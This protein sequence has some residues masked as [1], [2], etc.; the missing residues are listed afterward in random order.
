MN[1]ILTGIV[2][3]ILFSNIFSNFTLAQPCSPA[4]IFSASN[5]SAT[6][7]HNQAITFNN[8]NALPGQYRFRFY[9]S[10]NVLLSGP[11]A[12]PANGSITAPFPSGSGYK[13]VLIRQDVTCK[14]SIT[15][16]F[17]VDALPAA[18]AFT[19]NGPKCANTATAFTVT[20]PLAGHTYSWNFGD[21]ASG[22]ANTASGTTANHAFSVSSNG[23][24]ANYN[25]L[26][27]V[28]SPLGC[29][30][31]AGTVSVPV[32][33]TPKINLSDP[34]FETELLW[35]RCQTD[36]N[37]VDSNY[38]FRFDNHSLGSAGTNYTFNWGD[39]TP[40]TIV[41]Q[42]SLPDTINHLYAS[43]GVKNGTLLAT[44]PNGCSSTF[45]F[46]VV[47]EKFPSASLSI[48]PAQVSICDGTTV[49]ISNNSLNATSYTWLW[50]DGDSLNT[51][52]KS[53]QTHLYK[54]SDSVACKITVATGL[55]LNMKLKAFNTCW[56]HDNT[57]PIFV[58]PL[59]RINLEFDTLICVDSATNLVTVPFD[60]FVCPNRMMASNF[61]FTTI[62]FNDPFST[63]SNPDSIVFNP[64]IPLTN[65]SHKFRPGVYNIV[66]K[67][68]NSCGTTKVQKRLVIR[69][70]PKARFQRNYLPASEP[71][72]TPQN[73]STPSDFT[74]ANNCVPFTFDLKNLS[75][76]TGN[77]YTWT[78]TPAGGA[79]FA[80]SGNTSSKIDTTLRFTSPGTY[81]I[82]LKATNI[83]GTSL[84]C[85]TVTAIGPPV[86]VP[87]DIKGLD[88]ADGYS[89]SGDTSIACEPKLV[90][91]FTN[92]MDFPTYL[93]NLTGPSGPIAITG[94]T[95]ADPGPVILNAGIY[96]MQL[97]GSNACGPGTTRRF[98]K[99]LSLPVA[100]A[101][102]DK[103]ACIGNSV[104]GIGAAAQP[105]TLYQWNNLDG[106]PGVSAPNQSS[107]SIISNQAGIFRYEL[108]ATKGPCTKKDTVVVLINSLPVVSASNPAVCRKLPL[109]LTGNPAGG[110]W[111]WIGPGPNIMNLI[112]GVVNTFSAAGTYQVRYIYQDPSTQC[113]DSVNTSFTLFQLP[114]VK[115]RDTTV[116]NNSVLPVQL[117][118]FSPVGGGTGVWTNLSGPPVS[119]GGQFTPS[120]SGLFT[121]VYTFT[122]G[123]GCVEDDSINVSITSP[124]P[125]EAGPNR[126][127]CIDSIGFKFSGFSPKGGIW[128]GQGASGGIDSTFNP[129]IAGLGNRKII[130]SVGSGLCLRND[131]L[132]VNVLP[133]PDVGAG[134]D[135]D[136]VCINDPAFSLAAQPGVNPPAGGVWTGPGVAGNLFNPAAAGTGTHLITYRFRAA[137]GCDS[138]DTKSIVVN[139]LPAVFAR[140]TSVCRSTS[141]QSVQMLNAG[142]TLP[143]SGRWDNNGS[144]LGINP[145]G[146][147]IPSVAGTFTVKFIWKSSK[148]CE[149]V[150]IVNINVTEPTVVE[151]GINRSLCIDST[152]FKLSGFSPK[153]GIWSGPGLNNST[154]SSFNPR[155]A[156]IG[157]HIL[158][159]SLGSGLCLRN[160]SLVVNVLPLPD[161]GA[162]PDQDTV[163]I[164]DSPFSLASQAGVN[165]P[166]GGVWTGPGVA[167]NLFN[168]AAA[169]TG[170]HL[171]TYRFRAANGCD[172]SDT[173][174]IVVNPLPAVFARDTSFCR[175]T[176]G[177]IVQMANAGGD[178]PG[179][180]RWDDNGS[181]LGINPNG[182]FIPA[183]VGSFTVKFI[184]KNNKTCESEKLVTINVTEP[185]VVEAGPSFPTC[186]DS[187]N[188]IFTNFSPKGGIWSGSGS[189]MS[190]DSVFRPRIAGTGSHKIIYS[191]GSGLCLRKDSLI[192]TVNPLPNV[193]AGPDQDT[194]CINDL[195][196]SLQIQPGVNPPAG[197]TWVGQGVN[198]FMFNPTVAGTGTHTIT[199]HFRNANGCDSSDTK[200]ILVNPLPAVFARDTSFCRATGGT[201]VQMANAGG[202]LPGFGRWDDNGSG[203]GIDPNGTF[204][205]ATVGSFTVKFIW[206]NN[207][208]CE[209]EKIVTIHV[210]EPETVLAGP[211]RSTCLDSLGY[212]IGG[213]FPKGGIWTGSGM[214]GN[215]DSTF[216]PRLAGLGF[217]NLVYTVGEGLCLRQD[218]M[219]ILVNPLPSID[220]GGNQDTICIN[221]APFD[222][223]LISGVTSAF[224]IRWSIISSSPAG[225]TATLSEDGMFNP[226]PTGFSNIPLS[227]TYQ[228][229][230]RT[231][232]PI[233]GCDSTDTKQIIVNPRPEAEIKG[234]GPAI[235]CINEPIRLVSLSKSS[236]PGLNLI[237]N[238]SLGNGT[239]ISQWPNLDSLLISFQDTGIKVVRLSVRN[240]RTC[241]DIDSILIHI[242]DRGIPKYEK[243]YNPTSQ[244]G[245]LTVTFSDLSTGFR[246][247]TAWDLGDGNFVQ[248]PKIF[249]RFF[250]MS[251]WQD[252]LYPIRFRIIN[253]C[254]TTILH[255]T[256]LVKTLP[257]ANISANGL[258]HCPE[259]NL[260]TFTSSIIGA[261]TTLLFDFGDGTI[262]NVAVNPN[263]FQEVIQH[264]YVNNTM[265]DLFFTVK[266]TAINSCPSS[267]DSITIRIKGRNFNYE[268][269]ID[270]TVHC[271]RG[272]SNFTTNP[273]VPGVSVRWDLGDGTVI[274]NQTNF[275]HTYLVPGL[276]KVKLVS[277]NECHRMTDSAWVRVYPNPV[278]SIIAEGDTNICLNDAITFSN[279][280]DSGLSYEWFRDNEPTPWSFAY[281]PPPLLFPTSGTTQIRLLVTNPV[282]LC[283]ASD[284]VKITVH[285]SPRTIAGIDVVPTI[286]CPGD[287]FKV[288]DLSS[289]QSSTKIFTGDSFFYPLAIGQTEFSYSYTIPG[290][291][292][293]SL[294][295]I[296]NC[297]S[298]TSETVMVQVKPVPRVGFITS[299][300]TNF[301]WT[302][303]VYICVGDTVRYT[304][305]FPNQ[306]GVIY[307]WNFGDN[308]GSVQISPEP[309]VYNQPGLFKTSLQAIS[310]SP[311]NCDSTRYIWVKVKGLPVA[312]IGPSAASICQFG[313][314]SFQNS[315]IDYI[316]HRWKV[317]NPEGADVTPVNQVF[318]QTIQPTFSLSG[319]YTIRLIVS[320][321]FGDEG[322]RDSVDRLI[323]VNPAPIAEIEPDTSFICL[324]EFVQFSNNSTPGMA[325]LWRSFGVP[326]VIWNNNINQFTPGPTPN[327]NVG[328]LYKFELRVTDPVSGCRSYD[329]AYVNVNNIP[330]A[331]ASWT[332]SPVEACDSIR[333]TIR[334]LS[335][336][337]DSSR[338]WFNNGTVVSIP[339][340]A[341][342][343]SVR[344]LQP[345]TLQA[346]L[347]AYGKCT[348]DTTE[349]QTI[350]IRRSPKA[351]FSASVPGIP[352][353]PTDTVIICA[354]EIVQF[355]NLHPSV[356]NI[357]HEWNFGD[358]TPPSILVSP[359]HTYLQTG[360]FPVSL[361]ETYSSS[362]FCQAIA[363]KWVLV[364]PAAVP[365]FLGPAAVCEGSP[366]SFQ[367]NSQNTSYFMWYLLQGNNILDS[368]ENL[369]PWTFSA[370]AAGN[371]SVRI[372]V[373]GTISTNSCTGSLEK[374]LSIQSRP[375]ASFSI[376]NP[377][378]CLND[379]LRI[380]NS[381][382]TGMNYSW[383]LG[384]NNTPFSTLY[385]PQP[386]MVGPSGQIPVRLKVT[387]PQTGCYSWDTGFV[388][389]SNVRKTKA[390]LLV[391]PPHQGCDTLRVL[392]KNQSIDADSAWVLLGY[393]NLQLPFSGQNPNVSFTYPDTGRFVT[394][395]VAEGLCNKDTIN[396]PLIRVWP[397]PKADFTASTLLQSN[398]I[399]DT[400][401]ICV[402]DTV[403]FLNSF[404]LQQGVR[405]RWKFSESG[406]VFEG[407]NP[408]RRIYLNA[409]LYAVRLQAISD[410]GLCL[411]ER[412][413]FVRVK[414]LPI[415]S[416]NVVP[417]SICAGSEVLLDAGNTQNAVFYRW[418]IT[419]GDLLTTIDTAAPFIH[420]TFQQPG[421]GN[422]SIRL[423]AF[424]SSSLSSCSNELTRSI[425]VRPKP[426]PK[427]SLND[428]LGCTPLTIS[429]SR[430]PEGFGGQESVF[431]SFGDNRTSTSRNLNLTPVTYINPDTLEMVRQVKLKVSFQGCSDS[432][433][434]SIRV[435]PVPVAGLLFPEGTNLTQV[436][437]LLRLKEDIKP[438]CSQWVRY[439]SFGDGRDTTIYGGPNTE[440][441][442]RYD[443]TG[444]YYLVQKVMD[445]RYPDTCSAT[446]EGKIVRVFQS[447]PVAV[448]NVNGQDSC[449]ICEDDTVSFINKSRFV[450]L[451]SFWNF[452]NGRTIQLLGEDRYQIQKVVYPEPGLYQ[453]SL[454]VKN[455]KGIDTLVKKATVRVNPKPNTSFVL[456]PNIFEFP[457]FD[458][459][460]P[461]RT[462]NL[463]TGGARFL[464]N[465]GEFLSDTIEAFDTSYYY[466]TPG[467]YSISLVSISALGCPDT[468][469][470]KPNIKAFLAGLWVPD[471]FSPN[472]DGLN[473]DW[474]IFH[475]NVSS[476]NLFVYNQWGE[477]IFYSKNPENRW[478]GTFEGK[479]CPNGS[480]LFHITYTLKGING[481]ESAPRT[482]NKVVTIKR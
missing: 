248:K 136:T 446:L 370:P 250:P 306:A 217:H 158:R 346:W 14:D 380:T 284:T 383:F 258:T 297:V 406:A 432:S 464:W 173:K 54:L 79:N 404:P 378:I 64:N 308:S 99:I 224:G 201:V 271:N 85:A 243:S 68:K 58:K 329:T 46:K 203:L 337:R 354:G 151:A 23:L 57:S 436:N 235:F 419:E 252:T 146:S 127:I 301:N 43:F 35:K 255:D 162:G 412:L 49:T 263:N 4:A 293:V 36:G 376:L 281:S 187:L 32:K 194:V 195:P 198:G 207:K 52:S 152:G 148:T 448:F 344:F 441:Y 295:A 453:V 27:S 246:I 454:T 111:K 100:N 197:G 381:S 289:N 474:Q 110:V 16:A 372:K 430:N 270:D 165:P 130:Y 155:T 233:T 142:G 328:G 466:S 191:V 154:D 455:E 463:T 157:S 482:I 242:I 25:V 266:V 147:F 274:L 268:M 327:F 420:Y 279:L 204:I 133:L 310:I 44:D 163:C 234:L 414:P 186:I 94:A 389:V 449:T 2:I 205:P 445:W 12:V 335:Q 276:Y 429:F 451:S 101:G 96:T 408:A 416:I 264:G 278:A 257:V 410:S 18:P 304:N 175:A 422:T 45:P 180:G 103:T 214:A 273:L 339:R 277:F 423:I 457:I 177:T 209:S 447:P 11:T 132:V 239:I 298:D 336:F 88:V 440:I 189:S 353:W 269:T 316:Q 394:K 287:T 267:T 170:T 227:Y 366:V 229:L 169:G 124:N 143:G 72:T 415:I 51:T 357:Q 319:Q 452:G 3:L 181:G 211:D 384:N 39:G 50:G 63:P 431:W 428:S 178:L 347:V 434:R 76:G 443:T 437:P 13:A 145:N 114:V 113:K 439:Y 223:N 80:G 388:S 462:R 131:S 348:I 320:N 377:S 405:Y 53:P 193:N 313:I 361:R 390:R 338:V 413:R 123:N 42:S 135:Q 286:L 349:I 398:W 78:V 355:N 343:V 244:C 118:N 367:N 245:P 174:S 179:F 199:Y 241:E 55:Q 24:S 183:T 150:K 69:D 391:N 300:K 240:L 323:T 396:G 283:T 213:F 356:P 318:N 75:T 280:S 236:I 83:C 66:A 17:N 59:P 417:N 303:T 477:Q 67:A 230:A 397:S 139:P 311:G 253:Q 9:S 387:I 399:T 210:T 324:G 421:Q 261:P 332:V 444:T 247:E 256:I 260:V 418:E 128:I 168:P 472:N 1:K 26:L 92:R 121:Y 433:I 22:T 333:I 450:T 215:T 156:G 288:K 282:S 291:Y 182:T 321:T 160:D 385:N 81:I 105:N 330:P 468:F 188:V 202:D 331:Q 109:T 350:R 164:N 369:S 424:N 19:H 365:N 82:T 47:N 200:S 315:S 275:N 60:L 400:I 117:Q 33:A 176:G 171:I 21:P 442:H 184:W 102:P 62:I 149:S 249:T 185:T 285:P 427:I 232:N 363:R 473:D 219:R 368:A 10:A 116:C 292:P 89:I 38:T 20:G 259:P 342:Q 137:N 362:P 30:T 93:W 129:R 374:P 90:D 221:D 386:I 254:D 119:A 435:F 104:I 212:M 95:T 231:V 6:R 458:G 465:F 159:Y 144:A 371:Y 360:I 425:V 216:N 475:L 322:C 476:F 401:V 98:I 172:S 461:I 456:E 237:N 122:D 265:N 73:C 251:I 91:V 120:V 345:D 407:I 190:A 307:D 325:Y 460:E 37:S 112:T 220:A 61:T 238:W 65:I 299:T 29:Q 15:V 28:T 141:G 373:R 479:N 74:P 358:G 86:L 469:R 314:T 153:G 48:P 40:N 115:A 56:P 382:G 134:P 71:Q 226:N 312:Q 409:G 272:T 192:I 392:F 411:A 125:V 97:T 106:G 138:S 290:L 403:R 402:N 305:L 309:K 77:I 359:Q 228:I 364:K 70:W 31:N 478:N 352:V 375:N 161:V 438:F 206:K 302:D 208:T 140:D 7:C 334:D 341:N 8:L 87:S 393:N 167:G 459:S 467:N 225:A 107:S 351:A 426:V 326:A 34:D 218:T 196:F 379:S 84:S 471:A 470:L 222:L 294:I 166:A 262:Q 481:Q 340:P 126:N 108:V 395:L 317:I 41:P 5:I 480:Y 296:G